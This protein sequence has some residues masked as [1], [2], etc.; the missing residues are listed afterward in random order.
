[1]TQGGQ[2]LVASG[3]AAVRVMPMSG[4][5]A[6]GICALADSLGLHG[7]RIDLAGRHDKAGLLASTAEAL[8]FPDWF[9]HNWDAWFDCLVD[10]R[11]RPAGGY[12]LVFEHADELRRTSPE[13][14]DTATSILEEVAQVWSTRNVPLRVFVGLSE[15][16]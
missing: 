11:W 13:T 3:K 9:G 12:V 10:L 8:H 5:V 7:V 6:Q 4:G 2:G 15:S 16:N 1:M 14:F